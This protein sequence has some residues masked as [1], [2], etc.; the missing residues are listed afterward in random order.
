MGVRVS[1]RAL[2]SPTAPSSK[3][4]Q[5]QLQASGNERYRF[6]RVAG[7]LTW[8]ARACTRATRTAHPAE[9]TRRQRPC[10][11][12]VSGLIVTRQPSR[13]P[14]PGAPMLDFLPPATNGGARQAATNP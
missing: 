3:L 7:E 13:P 10:P 1:A 5:C 4:S 6:G 12:L 11:R 8:G 14:T 2:A 9:P